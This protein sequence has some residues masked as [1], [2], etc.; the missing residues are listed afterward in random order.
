M[1][2]NNKSNDST[3]VTMRIGSDRFGDFIGSMVES[4]K[5]QKKLLDKNN[6]VTAAKLLSKKANDSKHGNRRELKSYV[7]VQIEKRLL[8]K[9]SLS[10]AQ[11]VRLTVD[12]ATQKAAELGVAS[13]RK[14]TF[15][16]NALDWYRAYRKQ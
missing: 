5:T 8:E 12:D 9:P 14:D 3:R 4:M 7:C 2:N 16:R 13:F 1:S 11:A 6:E 10:I 15:E